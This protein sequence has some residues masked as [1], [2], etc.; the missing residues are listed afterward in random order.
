MSNDENHSSAARASGQTQS[1]SLGKVLELIYEAIDE[2][3][4]QLPP[5]RGMA[6]SPATVLFGKAAQLDSLGLVNLVDVTEQHRA[7]EA[8]RE[9]EATSRAV[10]DAMLSEMPFVL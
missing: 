8:L 3:N 10:G 5:G 7:Q 1:L 4:L 2:V 6:K 9:S